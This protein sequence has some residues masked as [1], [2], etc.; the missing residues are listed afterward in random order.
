MLYFKYRPFVNNKDDSLLICRQVIF[1]TPFLQL[2]GLDCAYLSCSEFQEMAGLSVTG[3]MNEETLEKM[4]AP[5]CGM[6]DVIKP[7]E[8]KPK[9]GDPQ[10][11]NKP[12]EFN[13][14]GT[15]VCFLHKVLTKLV[16]SST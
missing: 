11:L 14:Q 9:S 15:T 3:K 16:Y 2:F 8:R 7:S 12:L 1:T 13:T 10:R 5:R 4:L 6:P